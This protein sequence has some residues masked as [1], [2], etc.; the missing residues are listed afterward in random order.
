MDSDHDS[1]DDPEMVEGVVAADNKTRYPH[2]FAD[3]VIKYWLQPDLVLKEVKC[4][5]IDDQCIL[6]REYME[7]HTPTPHWVVDTV[8]LSLNSKSKSLAATNFVR[9]INS[10]PNITTNNTSKKPSFQKASSLLTNTSKNSK[11][12]N[13]N[14][15]K[16]PKLTA[17]SLI[18]RQLG[19][20]TS[21]GNISIKKSNNN[22]NNSNILYPAS[23]VSAASDA[24]LSSALGSVSDTNS[25]D[26]N[27]DIKSIASNVSLESNFSNFSINSSAKSINNNNN[28]NNNSNN[29]LVGLLPNWEEATANR[30]LSILP[31]K[32]HYR[33]P[34]ANKFL[35]N[36]IKYSVRLNIGL[37]ILQKHLTNKQFN[38]LMT[39][40][41]TI[42]CSDSPRVCD[43]F[44][45]SVERLEL[46]RKEIE[47]KK[48]GKHNYYFEQ[49][50]AGWSPVLHRYLLIN[51]FESGLSDDFGGV[52]R[53]KNLKMDSDTCADIMKKYLKV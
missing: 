44:Y 7:R 11:K 4:H 31:K 34:T 53:M 9:R 35:D 43:K 48:E 24:S 38:A 23:E 13:S 39:R 50:K 8:Q 12:T 32:I 21:Q 33:R 42:A 51:L 47:M 2:S 30:A 41:V 28:N 3:R 19:A 37:K 10:Q 27:D 36:A 49:I 18:S 40:L 52:L 1:E 20:P 17:E 25:I 22:N 15:F 6:I 29:K 45:K 14:N 16:A 5:A 26:N 46:E